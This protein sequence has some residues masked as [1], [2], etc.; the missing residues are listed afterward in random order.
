MGV[1]IILR[2][3]LYGSGTNKINK[4]YKDKGYLLGE[5][6]AKR[7]YTL[8]FG[9]GDD[10]MMGAVSH[11]VKDN[12]QEIIGIAP[13]WMK[14]FEGMNN[15]C[16]CKLLTNS[17]QERKK[18]FFEYSDAF[19]IVPGGLGTLDEF[20][21]ILTLKKLEKHN[22]PIIIYNINNFYNTLFEMLDFMVSEGC[23][24]KENLNLYQVSTSVK[25]TLD[26]I[27]KTI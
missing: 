21:E 18:L 1:L 5:E 19:I 11:G 12:N 14:D 6:I 3:C 8:V 23:I 26:L 13:D 25:E 7:G 22:K 20:F 16:T 24:D 27:E 15:N 4:E 10:G 9:A 2:I 17:M